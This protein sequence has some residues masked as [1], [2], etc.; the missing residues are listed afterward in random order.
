MRTGAPTGRRKEQRRLPFAVALVAAGLGLALALGACDPEP[1]P[2]T[3]PRTLSVESP[4]HY[5]LDL[6]DRRV[7]GET[8]VMVYVTDMGAVDSVYVLEPSGEAAF[9][10]AAVEGAR[11]LKFAPGRRGDD[12]IAMW[13]RLPVRFSRPDST[14][15]G[16]LP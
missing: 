9:D 10:S 8:V 13:A 7:E 4:F 14:D 2:D 6:W 1:K 16:A 3:N 15:S 12:R 5:P 11:S